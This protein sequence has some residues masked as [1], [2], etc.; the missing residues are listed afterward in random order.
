MLR[1][2]FSHE[3]EKGTSSSRIT[4]LT[5]RV[6]VA[7]IGG[8]TR[9][10]TDIIK[11]QRGDQRVSLEEKGERLSDTSTSAEDGDLG[12]TGSRGGECASLGE[13]TDS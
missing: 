3:H 4:D 5:G 10:T 1:S 11:A 9:S 7:D 13:A 2:I 12:L 6:D 8:D